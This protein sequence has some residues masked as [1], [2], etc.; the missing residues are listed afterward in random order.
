MKVKIQINTETFVRFILVVI[1]FGLAGLAIYS[2][3]TALLIIGISIFLALALSVPVARLVKLLPKRNRILATSIAYIVVVAVLGAVIFWVIPPIVQQTAKFIQ[4]V[5]DIAESVTESWGGLD[6]MIDKYNLRSQ[7]DQVLESIKDDASG[8]AANAG[9]ALVNGI[10]SVFN[11]VAVLVLVLVMAFLMIIEGPVWIKRLWGLYTNHTKME[12][13]R[14]LAERMY[15]VVTHYVSGQVMV[16]II[17]ALAAGLAVFI[18]SLI[19]PDLSANLAMPTIAVT[20]VLTLIPMFGATVAGI[21][22]G[23]LLAFNNVFAAVI[24]VIFF[25]IYQQIENNLIVPHVQAK[26]VELSPLAILVAVTVGI[27][28]F[29]VVG[30]VVAIPIAGCVRILVQDYL[31]RAALERT[32]SKS[33]SLLAKIASKKG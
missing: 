7:V 2:A 33:G 14:R 22:V 32:R 9:Q 29:G 10:G 18:L 23:L 8:F 24:Y 5:P 27:Y 19:F 21:I 11:F 25:I 3:R 31:D 26:T 17:G 20:F 4:T 12:Q 15:G 1:G 13:H 28:L 6:N 16:S 30:G